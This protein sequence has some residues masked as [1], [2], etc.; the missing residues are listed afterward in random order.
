MLIASSCWRSAIL[1]ARSSR[2]STNWP[3]RTLVTNLWGKGSAAGDKMSPLSRF[4]AAGMD[5]L[6]VGGGMGLTGVT[7][8]VVELGEYDGR[9]AMVVVVGVV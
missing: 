6:I 1:S 4:W 7:V 9:A 5:G 3:V 8:G 2:I